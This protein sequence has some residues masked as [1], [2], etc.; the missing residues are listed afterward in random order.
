[1]TAFENVGT[2]M[3]AVPSP[4]ATRRTSLAEVESQCGQDIKSALSA[5]VRKWQGA[6]FRFRIAFSPTPGGVAVRA[7]AIRRVV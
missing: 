2:F 6:V 7:G 3:Y 5:Q 1:M 4:D